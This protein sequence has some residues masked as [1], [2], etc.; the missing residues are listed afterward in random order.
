M[1]YMF[2]LIA[3]LM[4]GVSVQA[5]E[6]C[7]CGPY[8]YDHKFPGNS[9]NHYRLIDGTVNAALVRDTERTADRKYLRTEILI[10][11]PGNSGSYS[12]AYDQLASDGAKICVKGEVKT[13]LAVNS[14]GGKESLTFFESVENIFPFASECE[15]APISIHIDAV[16]KAELPH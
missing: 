13:A 9:I 11:W 10:E 6:K 8:R 12:P 15:G 14:D 3:L 5:E 4:M 2:P 16:K 7:L 1:K